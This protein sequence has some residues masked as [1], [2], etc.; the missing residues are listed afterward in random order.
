M[1]VSDLSEKDRKEI[2]L[3]RMENNDGDCVIYWNEIIRNKEGIALSTGKT[4][5]NEQRQ[6]FG[7]SG[8]L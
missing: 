4:I 8:M 1:K 5:Y 3:V 6:W 7:G 2:L